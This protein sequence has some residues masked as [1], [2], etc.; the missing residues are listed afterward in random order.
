MKNIE[1]VFDRNDIHDHI[2]SLWKTP[3]F[4]HSHASGGLVSQIIDRYA[5]L[6]RFFYDMSD[7][8]LER[9][10]FSVWWSGVAYRSYNQD[11]CSD[12]YLL[13]EFAHGADMVHIAGAHSEGFRRKMQDNELMASTLT[14]IVAYFDMPTLRPRTFNGPIFADRFMNDPALQAM[15]RDDPNRL[16][17][18]LYFR[19]RNA[20]FYPDRNDPIEMWLHGF[21]T[22]NDKWFRIWGLRYDA[23]EVAMEK[24]SRRAFAGDRKGALLELMEWLDKNSTNGVPFRTEAEKFADVYWEKR[25]MATVMAA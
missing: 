7:D 25:D 6:P 18:E 8:R 1:L 10:H 20:M 22:Q 15:W 5:S 21:T 17:Q 9:A 23:V 3:E 12:L 16:V 11:T 19:R 24:F 13:H 2:R 14:E 4:K